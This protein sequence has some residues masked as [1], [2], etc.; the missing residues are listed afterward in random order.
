MERVETCSKASI[1]EEGYKESILGSKRMLPRAESK[2][3]NSS[4][5]SRD[6]SQKTSVVKSMLKKCID[7]YGV[8][9]FRKPVQGGRP[10][11]VPHSKLASH[12]TRQV[13]TG[14]IPNRLLVRTNSK[15]KTSPPSL[16][17]RAHFS[18]T[19]RS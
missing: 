11:K 15:G 4:R 3:S 7:Q 14:G 5:V 16:Q 8:K 17:L 6:S 18:D 12:N 1:F 19:A 10:C 13:D 2:D 9:S